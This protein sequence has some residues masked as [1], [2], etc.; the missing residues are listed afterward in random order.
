MKR[1]LGCKIPMIG[2]PD[3]YLCH[4]CEQE[5]PDVVSKARRAVTREIN[6]Q[7]REIERQQRIYERRASI[8]GL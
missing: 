8:R 4:S 2:Q 1:C 5:H 3:N 7:I 6:A